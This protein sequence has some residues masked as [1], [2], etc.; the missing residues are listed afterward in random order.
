MGNEKR[1]IKQ[2]GNGVSVIMAVKYITRKLN[3]T[4]QPLITPMNFVG[5]EFDRKPA[6]NL[7]LI[8]YV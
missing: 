7:S 5:Q 3:S 4:R 1:F 2:D 8:H 6:E